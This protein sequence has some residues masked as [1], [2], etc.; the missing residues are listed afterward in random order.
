M[1]RNVVKLIYLTSTMKAF[2]KVL[3]LGDDAGGEEFL[4]TSS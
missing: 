1:S 3:V 2:I 4:V